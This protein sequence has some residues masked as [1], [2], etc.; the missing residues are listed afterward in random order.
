MTNTNLAWLINY[1]KQILL[2]GVLVNNEIYLLI[3][4]RIHTPNKRAYMIFVKIMRSFNIYTRSLGDQCFATVNKF[5]ATGESSGFFGFLVTWQFAFCL[6]L[7]SRKRNK[8]VGWGNACLCKWYRNF[9]MTFHNIKY[10]YTWLEMHD[11]YH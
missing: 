9:Q 4:E 7:T 5:S 1:P 11:I 10:Y 3:H 2:Q 8:R 6:I